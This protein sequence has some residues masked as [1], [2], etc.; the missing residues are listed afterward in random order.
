MAK[1]KSKIEESKLVQALHFLHLTWKAGEDQAMYCMMNGNKA[2][3]FNSII[4]AGTT[5]EED[6]TAC[7]HTGL[8]LSAVLRCGERYEITQLSP[9]K[10]FVRSI[11]PD[12]GSDFQAYVPCISG[13]SLL[14][15]LPDAPMAPVDD[16]LTDALREVA[17]LINAKGETLIEQS[18]QLNAGSCLATNRSLIIEAWHGFDLPSGLL[19]PKAIVSA[20]HKSGKHLHSFGCSTRTAT[21]HFTDGT[22]LRTQLFQEKWPRISDHL[23]E[24]SCTRPVPPNLFESA[25][26]VAPFSNDGYLYIKDGLISSHPF[27]AKEEGS[28]MKLPIGDKHEERKYGISNLKHIAPYALRWDETMRNDGTYWTGKGIRGLI[29]HEVPSHATNNLDDDIPF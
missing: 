16:R 7:P 20:I 19:L 5:I 28:V 2:V 24:S 6:L 12:G 8:M 10:L 13:D 21:F 29:W 25:K 23:N 17:P 9:L 26:K 4:A 1:R 22:W 18:I 27:E 3:S 14:W 15:A 11:E